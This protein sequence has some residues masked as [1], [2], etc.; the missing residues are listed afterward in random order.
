MSLKSCL[1]ICSSGADSTSTT[2]VMRLKRSSS[3]GATARRVD[4]VAPAGEQPGDPG[5]H[6]GLVLDEHRQDVVVGGRRR[7]WAAL[8]TQRSLVA[9]WGAATMSSFDAPAGTI[10]N[11]FSR[12]SVRKSMTTGRS[13]IALAFSMAGS[14]LLGRLDPDADA[15][16]RLGPHLVVGQVGRQVHLAVALLVE[17]LLP[18]ADHAEVGVVEDRDLD[19]DALGRGGDQLLGGHLEAAVAVDGPHHAVG[20]ADLGADGGRARRSPWCRARPSSPTCRGG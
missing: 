1:V 20:P 8:V 6:A 5:E 15:A 9:G 16:H 13:S 10:G 11:T 12:A 19:R 17:H 2:I 14:D 18:L 4:V 3:V 7:R